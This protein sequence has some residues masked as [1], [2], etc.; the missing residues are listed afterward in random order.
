MRSGHSLLLTIALSSGLVGKA[1]LLITVLFPGVCEKS[2]RVLTAGS[3][4][5]VD[6]PSIVAGGNQEGKCWFEMCFFSWG[7]VFEKRNI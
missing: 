4:E 1:S 5:G 3:G 2:S 6:E 7:V